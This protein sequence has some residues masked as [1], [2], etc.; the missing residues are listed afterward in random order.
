MGLFSKKPKSIIVQKPAVKPVAKPN[1]EGVTTP[2]S[3]SLSP[4]SDIEAAILSPSLTTLAP[5]ATPTSTPTPPPTSTPK[6]DTP[7]PPLEMPKLAPKYDQLPPPKPGKPAK[8][9]KQKNRKGGVDPADFL[10][11]RTELIHMKA[12]LDE[13]EQ[14]RAVVEARLGALDAAASTLSSERADISEVAGM[15][16]QLQQELAER[17]GVG[18]I[19]G[20]NPIIGPAQEELAAKVDALQNRLFG[21]QDHGDKLAEV[22]SQLA[23]MRVELAATAEAAATDTPQPVGPDPETLQHLAM[24]HQRLDEVDHLTQR[25]G[26]ID[27]LQQRVSGLG[28][29]EQRLASV[30]GLAAQL[31]QL[32]ARV[33]AQAEF[34]GQLSALRDRVGQL[35]DQTPQGADDDVRLQLQEIGERL[36]SSEELRSQ[37]GQ[38]AERMASNDTEARAV[39][40]HMAL[41][42]QRLTNVSTEL[43]N[44][45]SELG[46]DIDGLGQRVP[47][48]VDGSV[49]DEVVE[50]L[51]GGQVK[52]ANEQARY[53]I[54]FRQD[55]AALAEQLR[56]GNS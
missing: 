7:P 35:G 50:A 37:I 31:Q 32:N 25:I 4:K 8:P 42:D 30:D 48:I 52:L 24:V 36:Q 10:A 6:S 40:E 53:E 19:T 49:S 3:D 44:Q 20:D 5:T 11:L 28:D 23:S 18:A 55:L 27:Q 47:E 16:V 41:L 21:M 38:L 17:T 29:V 54:A 22:E 43:A 9:A 51:R 13:S 1:P 15:V 33:A 26:E 56:R 39:R 45:I 46:S 12:R 2:K 34:G 14:A